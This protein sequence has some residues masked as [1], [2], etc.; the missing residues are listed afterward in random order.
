MTVP[1][2]TTS[3]SPCVT[4]SQ[5]PWYRAL[6]GTDPVLDEHTDGGFRH[7]VWALDNG[8]LFGI[9][10]HDRALEGG[11]FTEFR[12]GLDHVGFGCA[13]ARNSRRG[14]SRLTSS[15]SSTAASWTPTTARG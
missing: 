4:S 10:Q 2:S 7:L 15:A 12:A 6:F 14:S 11:R 13:T 3:R 8:T 9:H 5:R 1:H